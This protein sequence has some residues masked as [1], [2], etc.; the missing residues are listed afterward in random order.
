MHSEE[1]DAEPRKQ[2]DIGEFARFGEDPDELRFSDAGSGNT[3][4]SAFAEQLT[5]GDSAEK[6]AA[7]RALWRGHSRKYASEV[8][9]YLAGPPPGG[10]DFRAFQRKVEAE[11]RPEAVL[12]ELK[13]G[14][15]LWGTWLAFLRPHKDYIPLLLDGLKTKLERQ[16]ETVLAL[17]N[18]GDAR[19]L[20]PL[21]RILKSGKY[22]ES[23]DAARAI[24]YLG[25]PKA[26]PELIKALSRDGWPQLNASLALAKFGSAKAIPALEKVANY[27]GY[28][29][30]INTRGVA[31]HAIVRIERR[32]TGPLRY[33]NF[34]PTAILRGHA[35]FV[36][37]FAF[38]PDAKALASAGDGRS[39]RLWDTSSGKCTAAFQGRAGQMQYVAFINRETIVAGGWGES[40]SIEIMDARTGKVSSAIPA[41][42]GAL[43][44]MVIS[45]DRK[46]VAA[47]GPNAQG[48]RVWD[49]AT[50]KELYSLKMA[51]EALAFSPDGKMLAVEASD[52]IELWDLATGKRKTSLSGHTVG[53]SSASFT[54]DGKTLVSCGDWTILVWDVPTGK[55]KATFRGD[56]EISNVAIHPDGRFAVAGEDEGPVRIWDLSTGKTIAILKAR[57]AV[58]LSPDGKMLA[59]GSDNDY[60]IRLWNLSEILQAAKKGR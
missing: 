18:S 50:S 36:W 8:L 47:S 40:G 19:A 6:L 21:L 1:P 41:A 44:S 25:D 10:N 26:E 45:S 59:T 60:S 34:K 9:K 13:E 23:G 54:A 32:T 2:P 49:I 35:E 52:S 43:S 51:H 37:S 33:S 22:R 58:A 42:D 27:K 16:P 5:K 4:E 12:R 30:A 11:L 39:I 56:S 24:G 20:E 28:T 57:G 38:S 53:A 31:R 48:V 46:R 17:G 15:Y 14:D 3:D 7:A 29:G 55:L